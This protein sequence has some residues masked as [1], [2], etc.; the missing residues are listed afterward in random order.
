MGN[1]SFTIESAG[2]ADLD[3]LLAIAQ[4]TYIVYFGH[5]WSMQGIAGHLACEF[6][7]KRIYDE[8]SGDQTKYFLAKVDQDVV[9]Y[10]K[11]GIDSPVP[12]ATNRGLELEKIYLKPN[13]T[14]R[15]IGRQLLYLAISVAKSR[16]QPLVWLDVLTSNA[17]AKSFYEFHG[18]STI[19]RGEFDTDM[20]QIGR[21]IMV[22]P[23]VNAE[24]SQL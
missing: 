22:K 4:E 7:P 12:G 17:R 19:G 2:T 18:F 5:L 23:L 8:L 11:V 9:G 6:E 10:M 24:S 20:H 1:A 14:G 16:L 13:A 3:S 21:W 15:G